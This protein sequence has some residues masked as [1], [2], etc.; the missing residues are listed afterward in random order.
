MGKYR[1]LAVLLLLL[2]GAV[3]PSFERPVSEIPYWETPDD[4][5]G[6]PGWEERTEE[7]R[8]W[9]APSVRVTRNGGG[10]SG[11]ICYYDAKEDWAYVISCGH[12]FPSG[13]KGA[14]AYRKAP[15]SRKVEVFYHNGE[16]LSKAESYTAE[17]LCHVWDGVYDV[18][19]LRFHPNWDSPWV[20]TIAPKDFKPELNRQYHSTGCD[21]L[22]ETAHYLPT[23]VSEADRGHVTEYR[24]QGNAPRKGR[25]GGG[26][27]TDNVEVFG[28]CSRAGGD[29]GYFSSV[30]QIHSF[31]SEEGFGFLLEGGSLAG[32]IP[33]IDRNNPQGTYPKTYIPVPGR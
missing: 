12:L 23:V 2:T 7:V 25:S 31:L 6:R 8:K 27:M 3:Q 28:I 17:V 1:Y 26:L 4:W 14:E 18:A 10:G 16:K 29:R 15:D 19:L 32:K 21:G 11:T 33:V 30:S 20:A 22:T 9:L 24:T 5:Y 13:R